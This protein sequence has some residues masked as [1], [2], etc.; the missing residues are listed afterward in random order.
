MAH[1]TRQSRRSSLDLDELAPSHFLIYNTHIN[2]ALK[3]EG[4]LKG[5]MFELT[6]WRREGLL[7]RLRERGYNVRTIADRLEALPEPPAPP[8]IGGAGWRPLA[9]AIEQMSHF[10]LPNMRWHALVP[11]TRAGGPGVTIYDGW[12]LRRR[13]GRGAASYYLAFKERTGG[14]GLRPLDETSALLTG[15]AQSFE[16][17]ARPLLAERRGDALLLP[18]VELPPPYRA[19]LALF[20]TASPEGPLVDQVGWP[21]AQDLFGRLGVRLTAAEA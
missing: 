12:V 3:G 19:T 8:P 9:S 4:V 21:L 11:E 5:R 13:K 18:N 10:D 6:T 7:A 20:S 16:R 15:L 14:I 17:D 1:P 2:S